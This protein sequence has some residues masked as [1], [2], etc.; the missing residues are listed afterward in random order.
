MI[1]LV[2]AGGK[3]TRM[4]S[5]VE[6]LFLSYNSSDIIQILFIPDIHIC[7]VTNPKEDNYDFLINPIALKM[8]INK[9]NHPSLISLE[10]AH[11]MY[12]LGL[13]NHKVSNCPELGEHNNKFIKQLGYT[14]EEIL[15][16][17]KKKIIFKN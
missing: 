11:N 10:M 2:M 15:N 17:Y 3:G 5:D 12:D 7:V 8:I 9:D 13:E 14:E 6:K 4:N 1:G 16:M